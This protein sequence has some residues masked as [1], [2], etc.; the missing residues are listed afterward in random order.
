MAAFLA[1]FMPTLEKLYGFKPSFSLVENYVRRNGEYFE[2]SE[3]EHVEDP[4]KV[5]SSNFDSVIV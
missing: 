2:I 4:D 5:E 1:W 3:L